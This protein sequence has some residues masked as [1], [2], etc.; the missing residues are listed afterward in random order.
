MNKWAFA[1]AAAIFASGV[2]AQ[3]LGRVTTFG[4]LSYQYT[5]EV[6]DR[7]TDE[8]HGVHLSLGHFLTRNLAVEIAGDYSRF[9][10]EAPLNRK[11]RNYSSKLG[12]L[13]AFNRENLIQPYLGLGGGLANNQL[14]PGVS[15]GG[16]VNGYDRR[17][18]A[19]GEATVGLMAFLGD[20]IGLRGEWAYRYTDGAPGPNDGQ[21]ISSLKEPILRVGLLMPLARSAPPAPPEPPAPTE[22]AFVDSDGDGVP[23]HLDECPGTPPGVRVDARGCPIDSDG[24]GVPDY[25]DKCPNTPAGVEVD[26]HGCPVDARIDRKFEDV[27]FGFDRDDLTDYGRVNLDKTADEIKGLARQ[28]PNLR[29]RVEGHT[30]SVGPAEY[31]MGLGQRRAQTV[32]DYLVTKG[33][34]G[35]RIE[36]RSA[37]ETRPVASNDTP[38]GRLLNRRVEI[39]AVTAE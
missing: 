35:Q 30:D 20:H 11:G 24:D 27:N 25:L 2:N 34:D 7:M 31:N 33:V 12:L 3:D 8:G 18:R 19:F 32:R 28:N 22:P 39:R 37:G 17:R 9:G 14:Y 38:K 36:T 1:A 21:A 29:V 23:D 10:D 15:D 13:Y 4:S 16:D 6:D 5:F 26:E